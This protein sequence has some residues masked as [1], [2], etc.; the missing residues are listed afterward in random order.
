MKYRDNFNVK[1]T[2]KE[3]FD[4]IIEEASDIGYYHLGKQN[5]E[6]ITHYADGVVQKH[7]VVIGIGGSTLGTSAIYEFLKHSKELEKRL[8]FLD[9]TDPVVLLSKIESLDLRDT[10]FIVISKSGM[11]VET[12]AIFKYLKS[13]IIIDKY[14]SLIIT[15]EDSKLNDYAEKN[16][17]QTFIVP[18]NVGGRFSVFS[19]VGLVPLAI[20]GINIKELLNGI[21]TI[22]NSFLNKKI[23]RDRLINKA[24][25]YVEYKNKYNINIIFSY[26]SLLESFNKWYVQ[27]WGE[28]L[29]KIDI[30]DARQGLTPIGLIGPIDQHSFLQ[31]IVEGKRDKSITFIKIENFETKLTIPNIVLEGLDEIDYI[32]GIS[33][34]KLI[35]MQADATIEV[36]N[37]LEEIPYDM[38]E[39]ETIS[40]TSIA[41]LMYEYELLTSIC[42]KFLHV[43][44]YN[45]PGVEQGKIILKKN[46][47][48]K[49]S[50]R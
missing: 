16:G 4:G 21:E 34:S 24:R 43:D 37:E 49:R 23:Y 50:N 22:Y 33:F 18:K 19:P 3:V 32:N 8:V 29:G 17:I 13:L 7:I 35:N 36:I 5:I 39:I 38:I 9:S 40:E 12:I 41:K 1:L 28:S 46:L 47:K 30:N 42:A 27:L 25:F 20:V 11:T 15:E 44:A 10:L 26:S 14:N 45:Q 2:D 31:L 6:K 48:T